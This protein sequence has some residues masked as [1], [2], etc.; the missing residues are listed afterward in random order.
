[1][2]KKYLLCLGLTPIL[3]LAPSH[4]E[5]VQTE[6]AR[7]IVNKPNVLF[8]IM[9]DMSDWVGMLSGHNQV[10]SPHLNRLS[11][12]GINFTNAYTVVPLSNPSRAALLT[13][14]PAHVSGVYHN[15][16]VLSNFP[17]VNNSVFMPQ[18][19]KNN[20]YKTVMSGKI[21]HTKPSTTV[22]ENMWDDMTNMDGGYGPWIQNQSLP[23]ELQ[24]QWRNYEAW[25]GPDTDFPDVV[26]SNKI[27]NYLG[28]SHEQPFF[29][30]MGFYR[31]HTPYTAPK[32]YFDLYN[33]DSIQ[34]PE[35]RNDDLDDLPPYAINNFLRDQ[36]FV[37][38]LYSTDNC[39]QQLVKAYL[40]CVSFAD[41]RIGKIL[42]TLDASP[43]ADNTLIVVIG[44]N[45]HHHGEKNHWNKSTLW[46][47]A[48]HVPMLI[49]PPKNITGIVRGVTCTTPVSLI[50]LY[51]TLIE[52][53]NLTEVPNQLAG[54]SLTPL[55]ENV[56][57]S[58]DVPALSTYLPGNFAVHQQQWNYIRYANGATE[59]YNLATDEDEF[60]NLAGLSAYQYMTD[61]LDQFVPTEWYTVPTAPVVSSISEDFS[62]S[63]WDA[64]LKRL[65]PGYTKPAIEATFNAINNTERYFDKYL[66]KGDMKTNAGTPNCVLDGVVHGNATAALAFRLKNDSSGFLELP[67]MENAGTLSLHVRSG[68][69]DI[70]GYLSLQQWVNMEWVTIAYLTI[71][72]RN[73][74]SQTAIDEII[75]Y[76]LNINSEVRLRIRG[77]NRFTQIFRFDVTPY[78]AL[79]LHQHPASLITLQGRSLSV[80]HPMKVMVYNT[81]GVLVFQENIEKETMLPDYIEEGI[82][83][84]VTEAGTQKIF[85][86]K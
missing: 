30:A 51:P 10:I 83:I 35:I 58:R 45:G 40:A 22:L 18:H 62:T 80:P 73:A 84:A 5:D 42:D 32:R 56:E 25:T 50:D 85:I 44:D 57:A 47:E 61:S 65:N 12:R 43:Y 77:G 29:A 11:E 60:H 19:F 55:I 79:G 41:D 49:V 78:S 37:K 76:P 74:Y 39:A 48:C 38:N 69:T 20:G 63:A 16:N 86:C 15:E 75:T 28:Q 14:I 64:E 33:V 34:L 17:I 23:P 6:K 52:M 68:V 31:P 71:Q 53:C 82:Y 36:S 26:N 4:A 46:R 27:I 54:I 72:G 13:G 2:N 9:D 3:S 81:M 59:L 70:T 7:S 67:P 24:L 1:M 66:M 21:L 8:I